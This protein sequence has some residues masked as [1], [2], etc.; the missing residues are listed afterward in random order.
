MVEELLK[1]GADPNINKTN[2]IIH[3]TDD[4]NMILILIKYGA[5]IT[6]LI[7]KK[8]IS[9]YNAIKK[10]VE[11]NPNSA[12]INAAS[13]IRYACIGS[14]KNKNNPGKP[15]IK[16]FKLLLDAAGDRVKNE[17][18]ITNIIYIHIIWSIRNIEISD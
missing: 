11:I 2:K 8:Y 7:Y 17:N 3:L 5:E 10:I 1:M 6:D 4:F 12:I 16:Q 14:Y 18:I 9:N 13:G 15:Y